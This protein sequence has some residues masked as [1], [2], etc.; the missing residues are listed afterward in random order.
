M[1]HQLS[2]DFYVARESRSDDSL[3]RRFPRYWQAGCH[4]V[5]RGAV[6]E[7][8]G[9]IYRERMSLHRASRF[10]FK[11]RIAS[12]VLRSVAVRSGGEAIFQRIALG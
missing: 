4:L 6:G 5:W 2:F 8:C 7:R 11:D 9:V 10:L 3:F 12:S 1:W